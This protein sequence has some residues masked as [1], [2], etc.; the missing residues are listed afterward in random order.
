MCVCVTLNSSS[1]SELRE[2]ESL[3][4]CVGQAC[5][6]V[7]MRM[8]HMYVCMYVCMY[9]QLTYVKREFQGIYAHV[10]YVCMYVCMFALLTCVGQECHGVYMHMSHM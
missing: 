8:S 6:G 3:L 5:H 7:Y 2:A 1:D 10:T 9:V 4:T